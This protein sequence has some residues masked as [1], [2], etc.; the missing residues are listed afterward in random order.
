M[1]YIN[2]RFTYFLLTYFTARSETS[3]RQHNGKHDD[4]G[5]QSSS[6]MQ[7]HLGFYDGS[8]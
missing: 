4:S 5:D 3:H 7:H 6:R 2:L 1:R 8:A